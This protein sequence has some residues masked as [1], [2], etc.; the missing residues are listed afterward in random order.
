MIDKPIN[1]YIKKDKLLIKKL[2]LIKNEKNIFIIILLNKIL[3]I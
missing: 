1:H 3:N 2:K